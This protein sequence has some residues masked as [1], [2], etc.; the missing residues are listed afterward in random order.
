MEYASSGEL[1]DYIVSQTRIKE[2]EACKIFQQVLAGIEYIHKLNVVHRD[3]KPENLLLDH[4]HQIKIVDFGLSNTY[5]DKELLKTACGS[6]CYAAP[7]MIAGKE[8]NGLKVDI[9]SSGVILFAMICGYLPFED[10]NTRKLYKKIMKGVY[11]SPKYISE[12][13]KDLIEKILKI[14]PEERYSIEQIR[15]HEWFNQVTQSISPGILVGY[16]NISVDKNI[17]KKLQE[18]SVD[19]DYARKCIEANNHNAISTGYYLLLKKYVKDGGKISEEPEKS[20][21]KNNLKTFNLN[22]S[23]EVIPLYRLSHDKLF[24]PGPRKLFEFTKSPKCSA[25]P[26][27]VH[28]RHLSQTVER[29]AS[30]RRLVDSN[31]V[32]FRG[33]QRPPSRDFGNFKLGRIR[34]QVRGTPYRHTTFLSQRTSMKNSLDLKETPLMKPIKIKRDI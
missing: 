18:F 31:L 3:L 7:E 2:Q 4:N 17:L 12:P 34:R 9:W 10:P 5:K 11:Q 6:P 22:L 23:Q 32:S 27:V 26:K 1:F 20:H 8:Y 33:A 25:S 14:N 15:S 19:V 21:V 28:S 16:Q 29:N 13:A 30:P 24:T